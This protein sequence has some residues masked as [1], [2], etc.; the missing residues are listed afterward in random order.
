MR[1]KDSHSQNLVDFNG[2]G[3]YSDPEFVWNET[4]GPTDLK[5][6]DSNRLGNNYKN[7]MF[8]G[9]FNNG[10][11]YNFKL[12]KER[13]ALRLDDNLTDHVADTLDEVQN[14]VLAKGFGIITDLEVGPDGYLY[15]LGYSGSIYRIVGD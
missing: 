3:N 9:D 2:N 13:T 5:F 11:L 12:D 4:V 14:S 1:L 8:I 15:V 7:T 6:F 10:Y